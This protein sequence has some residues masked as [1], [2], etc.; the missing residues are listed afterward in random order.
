MHGRLSR[1]RPTSTYSATAKACEIKRGAPRARP[2]A[3][4]PPGSGRARPAVPAGTKQGTPSTRANARP[5]VPEQVCGQSARADASVRWRRGAEPHR[6]SKARA[7]RSGRCSMEGIHCVTAAAAAGL[8]AH[9]HWSVPSTSASKLTHGSRRAQW[10]SDLRVLRDDA[11]F[12]V[13]FERIE[14]LRS[15]ALRYHQRR[16]AP[17]KDRSRCGPTHVV[18]ESMPAVPL[19]RG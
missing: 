9:R 11:E 3:G 4:R 5:T 6:R 8:C 17:K 15:P 14:Q 19:R 18:A 10:P 16:P 7:L 1:P 13:C 2:G 12:V